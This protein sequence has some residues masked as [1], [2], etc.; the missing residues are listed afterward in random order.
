MPAIT[1]GLA[2]VE[3]RLRALRR[4]LNSVTVQHSAYLASSTVILLLAAVI[5]VGLR[6]SAWTFRI[7]TYGSVLLVIVAVAGCITYARR[8]WL[9]LQD[10]AH[11]A[12]ARAQLTDRLATLIDL[13]LRPRPSRLA[14]LL[15]TQA[16]ALG[17]RWQ[18]PRI[19]PRRVPR[20]VFLFLA[21]LLAL[22]ATTV[23]ERRAAL[24]PPSP[25]T[26]KA[27]AGT[28]APVRPAGSGPGQRGTGAA[29]LEQPGTKGGKQFPGVLLTPGD[30]P[31]GAGGAGSG[32][33]ESSDP[34]T[35]SAG[36]NK[37]R[38]L[39]DRLQRNLR[40]HFGAD[41]P[42]EHS[43]LASRSGSSSAPEPDNKAKHDPQ[44]RSGNGPNGTGAQDATSAKASQRAGQSPGGKSGGTGPSRPS[45]PQSFQGSS[46]AAGTGSSP[47]GLMDPNA[48]ALA[49][50]QGQT[51]HFTLA[52]T[53][54]LR[55]VP[56]PGKEGKRPSSRPS[57]RGGAAQPGASGGESEA[58]L[59]DQQMAD[60]ALRKA[61]IP[62]EYED[63]V[64]RVYSSRDE[65]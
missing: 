61:E 13:R 15:V 20:S 31:G 49:G 28:A 38:S 21:A 14:P 25:S 26:A 35:A 2:E 27:D 43:Q 19:V 11:L 4:R 42:K 46:P 37:E 56:Q 63:L 29:V 52:I 65:P 34:S 3:E 1:L 53:S 45:T 17:A 12:D 10:T 30:S 33:E 59:S 39:T 62:P 64:R 51:Q 24:P 5:V 6:A 48:P 9:T 44:P 54:L 32:R 22:A 40:H 57:T 16:L 47:Q 55:P 23:L 7:A 58:A 36:T 50:N 18:A 41:A 60:D 8:R